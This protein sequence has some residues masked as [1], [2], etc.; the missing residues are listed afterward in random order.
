MKFLI[1]GAALFSLVLIAEAQKGIVGGYVLVGA[2]RNG[3]PVGLQ[4]LQALAASAATLPV[5][6]I[7]LSFVLPT[8]VYKSGTNSLFNTG[9]NLTASGDYGFAQLKQIISQLQT[10]G[11]EVFLSVGGWN[12]NC[13]PYLYARYSVGGYGPNTPN[14]WKINTY[15]GG[16]IN[17]CV[18]SNQYC[19]VCEPPSEGTTLADFSIFPEPQNSATWQSAVQFVTA[20]ATGAAPQWN[21]DMIPGR[22]WTDSKTGITTTVPGSDAYYT[23]NRDPYQDLVYLAADLGAAGI[24]LDYEEFWHADYYKTGTGP[25]QLTQTIYKYAAIAY[26]LQLNIKSIAPTL[27][28]STAAA[29]VG[30]WTGDWWGGNL[31]GVWLAIKQQY[32]AI[33]NFF[34]SGANA[35]GINVMTYDL[36]DNEQ[37]YECPASNVCTLDQQV[38]FYMNTY[39]QAAITAGVGYEIGTPAYPDPT[40]DP[41]NQLPLTLSEL[42]LIISQTQINYGNGFFWEMFKSPDSSSNA[43]PTQV[44]QAVCNVVNA[45]SSRCQGVIPAITSAITRRH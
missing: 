26:D 35:G 3:Q 14:Y 10:G 7:W 23:Q 42:Q 29:A 9:L 44:A 12:Y 37:Y 20:G 6:R 2:S 22:S 33:I 17:N 25:Y 43:S 4:E 21:Y 13:F 27:K 30:A 24:D 31:K 40:Q 32:P 34:T 8:L 41:Q 45:G 39:T 16:N 15:G 1:F 38:Q 11:V 36:S 5:N 28:L 18:D 19:Y